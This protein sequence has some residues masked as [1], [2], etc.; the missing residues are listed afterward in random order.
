MRPRS[1][2][3]PLLLILAGTVLLVFNL[4]PGL[5]WWALVATWWPIILV[6]WGALRA[7]EILVWSRAG[8]PLPEHGISPGEWILAI[9]LVVVGTGVHFAYERLPWRG[10]EQHLLDAFGQT[11][12]YDLTGST[13]CAPDAEVVI[14]NPRGNVEIVG[15]QGVSTVQVEGRLWIRALDARRAEEAHRRIRLQFSGSERQVEVGLAHQNL[16]E[17]TQAG[18]DLRVQLPAGASVRLRGRD[19]ELELTGVAG[20]VKIEAEDATARLTQCCSNL[21]LDL[22]GARFVQISGTS[23]PVELRGR[24]RDVEVERAQ[25]PVTIRGSYT[26]QLRLRQLPAGVVFEGRRAQLSV[27][28]LD[29]VL[30]MDSGQLHAEDLVGPLRLKAGSRDI[31]LARFRGSLELELERGD[32]VLQPADRQPVMD[33]RVGSGEIEL[34]VPEQALNAGLR[35]MVEQGVIRHEFGQALRLTEKGAGAELVTPGVNRPSMLVRLERGEVTIRP[36]VLAAQGQPG[37]PAR[38]SGP[39]PRVEDY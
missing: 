21:E 26:G 13:P 22:R 5:D 6:V 7:I 37:G 12:W 36:P 27:T 19:G 24:G 8:H 34:L 35:V 16:P 4:W 25:G 38:L 14:D 39:A 32:V 20:K 17:G 11:Y 23:G 30:R 18:A 29:G 3:T 31:Q 2:V 33:V 28:R 10:L 9:L 15:Q 1:L